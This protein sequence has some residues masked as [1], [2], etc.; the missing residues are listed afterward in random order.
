MKNDYVIAD[1]VVWIKLNKRGK[2]IRWTQIE[3]TDFDIANSINGSWTCNGDGVKRRFYVL[4]EEL[5]A[6]GVYRTLSLHNL[7][8]I[9]RERLGNNTK[10][11]VDHKNND[12]LDNK[13]SNLR[14]TTRTINAVNR[15]QHKN[16]KS[17]TRGVFWHE[18]QQR[19]HASA[20]LSH[21]THF[22]GSFKTEL[23][24]KH[25]VEAFWSE[26][27]LLQEYKTAA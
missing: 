16:N 25:A 20:Q 27:Q 6:P 14:Y 23:E 22:L 17:G 7:L 3:R 2:T 19:W 10:F 26:Q 11:V 13:R 5:I 15:K 12:S 1:D 24:A 4:T 9:G 18:E 21:I 8:L